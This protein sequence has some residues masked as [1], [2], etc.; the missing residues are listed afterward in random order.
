MESFTFDQLEAWE[1]AEPPCVI[2]QGVLVTGGKLILYGRFKTWKSMIAMHAAVCISQG[3]PWFGFDVTQSPVFL[4]QAEIPMAQF[5]KRLLKYAYHHG[6]LPKVGGQLP[7][8]ILARD[9]KIRLDTGYGADLLLKEIKSWSKYS[10]I[11]VLIID[12]IYKMIQGNISDSK[13]VGRMQ[14]NLEHIA[15]ELGLSLIL[16]HHTRKAVINPTTGK[17]FDYSENGH[18]AEEMTGSLYWAN[19]CDGAVDIQHKTGTPDTQVTLGFSVMRHAET[20]LRPIQANIDR[21]SLR[22]DMFKNALTQEEIDDLAVDN[23]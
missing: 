22:W 1:P 17:P 10:V 6:C 9:P 11:K 2:D 3:K 23:D 7:G 20:N 8:L 12:P 14:Y 18:Y 15:E 5:R 19:W 16:V 13:D 21:D 4:F